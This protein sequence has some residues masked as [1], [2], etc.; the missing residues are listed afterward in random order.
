ML[1][2]P[3]RRRQLL[4]GRGQTRSGQSLGPRWRLPLR[5]DAPPAWRE[6]HCVSGQA[7]RGRTHDDS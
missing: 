3:S 6:V 2:P 1:A 7:R 5:H 4:A